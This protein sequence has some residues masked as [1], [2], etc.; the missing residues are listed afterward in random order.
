MD[1]EKQMPS[2]AYTANSRL[3]D[4]MLGWSGEVWFGNADKLNVCDPLHSP[5]MR[6]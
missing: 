3:S 4:P 6:I 2:R 1:Y 5:Q